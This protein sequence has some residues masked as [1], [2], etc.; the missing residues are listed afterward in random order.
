MTLTQTDYDQFDHGVQT[1]P[2]GPSGA[3]LVNSSLTNPLTGDGTL[4]RLFRRASGSHSSRCPKASVQSGFYVNPSADYMWDL[5]LAV[6]VRTMARGGGNAPNNS[7]VGLIFKADPTLARSSVGA[8]PPGYSLYVHAN[9]SLNVAIGSEFSDIFGTGFSVPDD[10]W[11]RIRMT[12]TP[13]PSG[14]DVMRF[15]TSP[16][17][18]T[19]WTRRGSTF[20]LAP[21]DA[22]FRPWGAGR[23]GFYDGSFVGDFSDPMGGWAACDG[24][25]VSRTR[26]L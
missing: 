23:I 25:S 9:R 16:P 1:V 22:R 4:A 21:T 12:V 8:P 24:F 17:N 10:E 14:N 5:Q 3:Q 6:R 2:G 15:Y 11:I 20:N 18:S 26:I 7:N 19:A 13:Q